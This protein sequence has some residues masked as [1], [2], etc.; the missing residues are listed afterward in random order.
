MAD[1]PPIVPHPSP[2]ARQDPS[3]WY[4]HSRQSVSH[5]ILTAVFVGI[6]LCIIAFFFL[7]S[8]TRKGDP[9]LVAHRPE[10]IAM[11]QRCCS[12]G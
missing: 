7:F 2:G 11:A 12:G 5:R 4:G 8:T 9:M 10:T 6:A 1:I 3:I